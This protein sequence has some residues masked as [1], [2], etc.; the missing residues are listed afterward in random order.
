M[1]KNHQPFAVTN[2]DATSKIVLVCDHATNIIPPG[3]ELGISEQDMTRH[4]AWDI[5]A[6]ELA[7][8]LSESLH[9]VLVNS[10]FSRLLI[11]PNR[12]L[13]DPSLM[14]S[15]SDRTHI[16]I[17]ANIRPAER[18]KRLNDFYYPY[19][20]KIASTIETIEQNHEQAIPIFIH[21]FTPTLGGEQRPWH[22]GV[23][24]TEDKRLAN[25]LLN[26]LQRRTGLVVGDNKPYSAVAPR[27]YTSERHAEEVGRKYLLLEIRQDLISNSDGVKEWSC[28]LTE[29]ILEVIE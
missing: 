5:G 22:V 23:L 12:P 17:N 16:P 6:L 21:S 1:N 24:S 29:D 25:P 28:V 10:R 26:I 14:P 27:G 20:A 13:D 18:E 9:A 11:D 3:Y 19:H 8:M 7:R 15:I 2:P 4:I